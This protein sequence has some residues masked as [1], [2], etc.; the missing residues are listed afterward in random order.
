MKQKLHGLQPTPGNRKNKS[1]KNSPINSLSNLLIN[2][3][4][5]VNSQSTMIDLG[6]WGIGPI[7][8]FRLQP[9]RRPWWNRRGTGYY[10]MDNRLSRPDLHSPTY[11]LISLYIN[12]LIPGDYTFNVP[13]RTT[14]LFIS[15]MTWGLKWPWLNLGHKWLFVQILIGS[16]FSAYP[17]WLAPQNITRAQ[18][19]SKL[20]SSIAIDCWLRPNF[21]AILHAIR[22]QNIIQSSPIFSS[23]RINF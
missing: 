22:K 2:K 23:R 20:A 9:H 17:T 6:A 18:L 11:V 7:Y 14:H 21:G 10:P 12:P 5:S 16:R 13:F 15:D 19:G 8:I 4:R 1:Q 3:S